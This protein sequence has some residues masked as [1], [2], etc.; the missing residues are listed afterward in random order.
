MDFAE[1]DSFNSPD[2]GKVEHY[3]DG[4]MACLTVSVSNTTACFSGRADDDLDLG[5]TSSFYE[6]DRSLYGETFRSYSTRFSGTCT[7]GHEMQIG[8]GEDIDDDP[9]VFF[10]LQKTSAPLSKFNPEILGERP[11]GQ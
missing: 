2:T 7:L 8:T 5:V 11:Q 4:V 10:T 3:F 6:D 1:H 9:V